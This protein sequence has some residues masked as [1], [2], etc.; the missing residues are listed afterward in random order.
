MA[1]PLNPTAV[2]SS[3]WEERIQLL[4]TD[5]LQNPRSAFLPVGLVTLLTKPLHF[6]FENEVN[7]NITNIGAKDKLTTRLTANYEEHRPIEI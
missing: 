6:S 3:T 7:I 4:D 2:F 5:W 1:P